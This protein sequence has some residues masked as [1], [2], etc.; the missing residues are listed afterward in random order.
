MWSNLLEGEEEFLELMVRMDR[1]YECVKQVSGT[2]L[3][4]DLGFHSWLSLGERTS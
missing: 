4:P 1:F 2:P 3:G